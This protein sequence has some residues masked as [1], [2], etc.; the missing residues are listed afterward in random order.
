MTTRPGWN[1]LTR[2]STSSLSCLVRG[3]QLSSKQT[4]RQTNEKQTLQSAQSRREDKRLVILLDYVW[5]NCTEY[6]TCMPYRPS[7]NSR[8]LVTTEKV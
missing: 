6:S 7:V 1:W 3:K 4:S 2:K 8:T 5:N